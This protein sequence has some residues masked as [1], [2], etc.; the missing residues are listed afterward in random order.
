MAIDT[1]Q[2]ASMPARSWNAYLPLLA[3][4]LIAALSAHVLKLTYQV[5]FL[6]V[7]IGLW[8]VQFSMIKLFDLEDFASKFGQY[9]L[10]ALRIRSY[11]FLFPFIQLALGLCFLGDFMLPVMAGVMILLGIL[12]L[13]GIF[14]RVKDDAAFLGRTFGGFRRVPLRDAAII[15]SALMILLGGAYY[16]LY[17]V[18]DGGITVVPVAS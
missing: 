9:D 11:A 16:L 13:V 10:F 1:T 7:F 4:A 6:P 8:L 15:E 18:F 2:D 14:R 12:N 3:T 17:H 5:V